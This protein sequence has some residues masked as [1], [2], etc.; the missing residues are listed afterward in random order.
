MLKSLAIASRRFASSGS[1]DLPRKV[2][3]CPS[4]SIA[5]VHPPQEFP[6]EHT[7]PIEL[8]EVDKKESRLSAE[9][10]AQTRIPR[11]PENSEL[12][13]IFYTTKHEWFSRTREER[14][15]KSHKGTFSNNFLLT[16]EHKPVYTVGIRSKQYTEEEEQRLKSLGA[17]FYRT[18]RG[19]LITFHGPGQLVLYPICDLRRIATKP[20]G[21]RNFVE[22]L[23]QTIIDCATKSFGI[24]NV[25]RT[26][27][28]GVWVDEN[29]KLAALGIAVSH[30]ISY[31]GLAINCS[32]DLSWFDNIVGCGI[33]NVST[34]SISNELNRDVSVQEVL[35]RMIDSFS[36][37]FQCNIVRD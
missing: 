27:H 34:T 19:G 8:E 3:L 4:G 23:E 16:L 14:L 35:P 36:D 13:E 29:R 6:Y 31:H 22:K 18:S 32:T 7:R 25:G 28:T 9:A 1:G 37:N 5:A 11:E 20:L 24:S 26:R 33:E 2:V 15:R 12:K 30:G 10:K 17:D 21:V